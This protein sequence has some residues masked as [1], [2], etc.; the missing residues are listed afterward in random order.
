MPNRKSPQ[1]NSTL[2][3]RVKYLIKGEPIYIIGHGDRQL[4]EKILA[5]NGAEK[6]FRRY[7]AQ[8]FFHRIRFVLSI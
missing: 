3:L 8:V 7:M 1:P 6:L 2:T 4:L 5:D